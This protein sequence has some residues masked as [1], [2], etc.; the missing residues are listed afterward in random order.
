MSNQWDLKTLENLCDP[1][2][3]C[4][5]RKVSINLI[6][7]GCRCFTFLH[8]AFPLCVEKSQTII[9]YFDLSSTIWFDKMES[10]WM[11]WSIWKFTGASEI[12]LERLWF[13]WSVW[14]PAWVLEILM[15]HLRFFGASVE[16]LVPKKCL[17]EK[18]LPSVCTYRIGVI[19]FFDSPYAHMAKYGHMGIWHFTMYIPFST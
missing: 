3:T 2:Y 5:T 6:L 14:E 17:L 12:L 18:T 10:F 11:F 1:I 13:Y 9:V 4:T 8:Y 16:S 7:I 19:Y 15:E